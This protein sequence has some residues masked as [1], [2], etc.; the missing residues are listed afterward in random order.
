ME[1]FYQKRS[2]CS[3]AALLPSS[4]GEAASSKA[5]NLHFFFKNKSE[6]PQTDPKTADMIQLTLMIHGQRIPFVSNAYIFIFY[7]RICDLNSCMGI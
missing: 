7:Y 4:V 2:Q 3:A 6:Q 1:L 5:N